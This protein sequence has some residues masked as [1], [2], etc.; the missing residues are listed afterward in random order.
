[1]VRRPVLGCV[2]EIK[3]LVTIFG[4]TPDNWEYSAVVENKIQ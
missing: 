2:E 4:R 1:M 3:N